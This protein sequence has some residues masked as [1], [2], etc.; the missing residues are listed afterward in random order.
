L[1]ANEQVPWK[2]VKYIICEVMYGGHI[3]DAWDRRVCTAYL[4]EVMKPELFTGMPLAPAFI[5]PKTDEDYEYYRTYIEESFPHESPTLFGLHNNAEIGFLLTSADALFKTIIDISGGAD[6]GAGSGEDLLGGQIEK[7]L[8]LLPDD[9]DFITLDQRAVERTPYQCVILQEVERM[10]LLVGEIRR[11]LMEL[12]LGLAGALNMSDAMDGLATAL[13]VN[14]VPAN[15]SKVAYPSL[16]TLAGWYADIL[17]RCEQLKA[18]SD[19]LDTPISVWISGLFNPMA[20]ITAVLQ[21]TAR[22]DN[23]PLDLMEVQTDITTQYNKDAFE[24]Y[25]EDGMYI[26]GCCMEGARWDTKKSVIADSNPKELHPVMPVIQ[27]RGV[28]YDK[29]DK[30]GIFDCPVFI[31]TQRGNTFTFVATLKTNDPVNKWVLAG[32]AIMM[33]DDLAA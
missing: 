29:V 14:R 7:L 11:S 30:S 16:K 28:L 9:F 31:T 24:A 13:N 20:Y 22:K 4:E 21:T 27:V 17:S 33:S 18:W 32:V 2:D 3:T 19:S 15:W 1:N 26:H 6:A 5:A 23:L 25:P 12:Q 8:E 10:N